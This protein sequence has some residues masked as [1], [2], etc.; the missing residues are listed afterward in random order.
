MLPNDIVCFLVGEEAPEEQPDPR[1]L[2]RRRSSVG[3]SQ[4]FAKDGLSS[5]GPSFPEAVLNNRSVISS[6]TSFGAGLHKLSFRNITAPFGQGRPREE[7]VFGE[8]T[9]GLQLFDQFCSESFGPAYPIMTVG[10]D[11]ST[12]I[13]LSS[14]SQMKPAKVGTDPYAVPSIF[15]Q[16]SSTI[17]DAVPPLSQEDVINKKTPAFSFQSIFD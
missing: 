15:G 10:G 7:E 6:Q 8:A 16:R 11:D 14:S 4:E 9:E 12:K 2:K 1:P 13:A 3:T 17:E 5:A